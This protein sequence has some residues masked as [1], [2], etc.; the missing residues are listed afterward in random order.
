MCYAD[1]DG[2]ISVDALRGL[3]EN[4][5]N[6]KDEVSL[7]QSAFLQCGN[8]Y[9]EAFHTIAQVHTAEQ[10]R[11]YYPDVNL[12][13]KCEVC[14]MDIATDTRVWEVKPVYIYGFGQVVGYGLVSHRLPVTTLAEIKDVYV[15][16]DMTMDIS[17]SIFE[18]GVIKYTLKLRK[19]QVVYSEAVQAIKNAANMLLYTALLLYGLFSGQPTNLPLPS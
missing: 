15:T 14:E 10:L 7:A 17:S 6:N 2:K 5:C 18:P 13:V 11:Y 16:P 19:K 9:C 8:N 3:Y 4:Y 1:R 12:E